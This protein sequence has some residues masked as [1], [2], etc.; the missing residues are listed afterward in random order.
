M[1]N[2]HLPI[3]INVSINYIDQLINCIRVNK[4]F[5]LLVVTVNTM[6]NYKH[7]NHSD[8]IS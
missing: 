4:V 3:N 6:E 1:Q 2:H 5:Q 8:E 7:V